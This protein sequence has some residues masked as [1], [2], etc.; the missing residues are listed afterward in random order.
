LGERFKKFQS[1]SL[2]QIIR[3]PGIEVADMLPI[4][5]QLGGAFE[6]EREILERATISIR[7]KGYI[8]KQDR[9]ISRFKKLEME[10]IPGSFEYQGITGL[11]NEAREKFSRF[12]PSSLGQ[13]GRIEGIT[14]GDL[15]VLSVHI[16]RHKSAP[17]V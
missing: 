15:A 12:R 3:Q 2:D 9:E 16:K 7:Y 6:T 4:L 17:A 1:V 11:R 10:L 13:A 14:P 5:A 8:D